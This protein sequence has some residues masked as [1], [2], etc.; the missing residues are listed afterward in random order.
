ME[1]QNDSVIPLL[2]VL[3]YTTPSGTLFFFLDRLVMRSGSF[4]ITLNAVVSGSV[5]ETDLVSIRKVDF[6][7]RSCSVYGRGVFNSLVTVRQ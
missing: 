3:V 7:Q 6:I 1:K 4:I 5:E 2:S